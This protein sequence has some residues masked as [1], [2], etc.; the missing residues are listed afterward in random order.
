MEEEEA[1][2]PMIKAWENCLNSAGLLVLLLLATTTTTTT[3][4][5]ATAPVVVVVLDNNNNQPS[6]HPEIS[7]RLP[8]SKRNNKVNDGAQ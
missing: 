2:E 6:Y 5:A 8:K 7:F 1:A 3:P 4:A